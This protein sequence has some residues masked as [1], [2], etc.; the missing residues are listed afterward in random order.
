[1]AHH[2]KHN[3]DGNC[4]IFS[5]KEKFNQINDRLSDWISLFCSLEYSEK[6]HYPNLF[7]RVRKGFHFSNPT[8]FVALPSTP[9]EKGRKVGRKGFNKQNKKQ[10]NNFIYLFFDYERNRKNIPL[11]YPFR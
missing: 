7:H 8:L 3:T 6:S 2:I 9:F 10:K 4:V 1:M 11:S 5:E